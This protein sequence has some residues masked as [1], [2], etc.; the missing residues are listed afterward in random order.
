ME[1][2]MEHVSLVVDYGNGAMKS[3]MNLPWTQNMT[4][5]DVLAA[6]GVAP[7]GLAVEQFTNRAGRQVVRSVDGVAPQLSKQNWLA[8]I[9]TTPVGPNFPTDLSDH[10]SG[11]VHQPLSPGDVVLLKLTDEQT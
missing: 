11:T 4:I 2:E 5:P 6:A 1:P 3:F 7:P 9:G 10:L 8:W